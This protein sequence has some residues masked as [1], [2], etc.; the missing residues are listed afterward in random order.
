MERYRSLYIVSTNLTLLSTVALLSRET[1]LRK[2]NRN[3]TRD[4]RIYIRRHRGQP[5]RDVHVGKHLRFN[6]LEQQTIL[7][8]GDLPQSIAKLS[9]TVNATYAIEM[10][11]IARLTL[12]ARMSNVH[13]M[14]HDDSPPFVSPEW[15]NVCWTTLSV[16]NNI[17]VNIFKLIETN[18]LLFFPFAIWQ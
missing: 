18:A 16:F 12:L 8:V 15:F 10:H 9:S 7:Y 17:E 2:A 13:W 6:G 3:N 11:R 4:N 5:C 1:A 14:S